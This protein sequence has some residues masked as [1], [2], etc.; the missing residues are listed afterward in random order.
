MSVNTFNHYDSDNSGAYN[1]LPR[2]SSSSCTEICKIVIGEDKVSK[3]DATKH[4]NIIEWQ[5]EKQFRTNSLNYICG[6]KEVGKSTLFNFLYSL[7]IDQIEEFF[8]FTLQPQLYSDLTCN[9][10]I[11]SS[12]EHFESLIEYFKKNQQKK[13]LVCIDQLS[14][15]INWKS[16]GVK[17]L[18]MQARHFN[19]TMFIVAQYPCNW[20]PDIRAQVD[21]CF[22]FNEPTKS[23]LHKIYEHHCG[24]F[25]HNFDSFR[26]VH[27]QL[28]K[29]YSSLVITPDNDNIYYYK[30]S[31]EVDLVKKDIIAP[32]I[33]N[34]S[35]T[36]K[37]II[38]SQL[39]QL[40]SL[41]SQILDHLQ[42]IEDEDIKHIENLDI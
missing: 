29:N 12:F 27:G 23:Y 41:C 32:F 13:R 17:T 24:N 15:E 31:L 22:F 28:A 18:F 19:V 40:K 2:H 37:Q 7:I 1:A 38:K 42:Y 14:H 10:H 6:K 11:F 39:K 5:P 8:V 20:T 25:F 36:N 34:Q 26:T 3:V 4:Y 35:G 21:N 33:F 9:A 16:I 30:A